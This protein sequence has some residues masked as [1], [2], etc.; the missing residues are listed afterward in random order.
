[1]TQDP[2]NRYINFRLPEKFP[3][4]ERV[5]DTLPQPGAMLLDFFEFYSEVRLIPILPTDIIKGLQRAQIAIY[6][7]D[8][9]LDEESSI[10][11]AFQRFISP[12]VMVITKE[13][14]GRT[15]EEAMGQKRRLIH[16]R[17]KRILDERTF[18]LV[19]GSKSKQDLLAKEAFPYFFW[20]SPANPYST[21]G[22]GVNVV[23]V[24]GDPVEDLTMDIDQNFIILNWHQLLEPGV[25]EDVLDIVLK[26]YKNWMDAIESTKRGMSTDYGK[27]WATCKTSIYGALARLAVTDQ[28]KNA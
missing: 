14:L 8:K 26:W 16:G 25:H 21:Y 7:S 23:Q 10:T 22:I 11:M 24:K 4:L 1:M 20:K 19:V 9:K 6:R 2:I 13:N 12:N 18:H 15:M 17:M 28:D 5:L 27:S 3:G